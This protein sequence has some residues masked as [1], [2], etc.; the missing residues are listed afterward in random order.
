[1]V[2]KI[3]CRKVKRSANDDD[4]Q[5]E[6]VEIGLNLKII[7]PAKLEKKEL[8]EKFQFI[9]VDFHMQ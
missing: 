5:F 3:F 4:D 2:L 9:S 8:L 1:L 6:E 7:N